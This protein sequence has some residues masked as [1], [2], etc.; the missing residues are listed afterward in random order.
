LWS[1]ERLKEIGF[2]IRVAR[3]DG[4]IDRNW[5]VS[6]RRFVKAKDD[7]GGEDEAVEWRVEQWVGDRAARADAALSKKEQTV[8][9]HHSDARK[10]AR[11]ICVRLGLPDWLCDLIVEVAGNHDLGKL[12]SNWQAFAGNFGFPRNPLKPQPLAKFVTR[13]NPNLLKIGDDT[14]RH[15]F[16]SLHEALEKK[17]FDHFPSEQ[18][19]L[20]LHL[21]AAHH[22]QARPLI[23]PV[24]ENRVLE[25]SAPLAREAALR[26]LRVQQAWGPWALAWLEGLVRAADRQASGEL[27]KKAA[28]A[29]EE[30]AASEKEAA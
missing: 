16:G 13:G 5:R 19:D 22:G 1:E 25:N 26:F 27:N 24:D 4:T 12:R 2:R 28:D 21:I 18:R 3:S 14:Y 10:T 8:D 15:E 9:C 30:A 6:Y 11:A 20:A 7:E 17:I 29:P 23:S